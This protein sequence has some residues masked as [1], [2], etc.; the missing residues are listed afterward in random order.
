MARDLETGA[1]SKPP[2]ARTDVTSDSHDSATPPTPHMLWMEVPVTRLPPPGCW[3]PLRNRPLSQAQHQS[4]LAGW[5]LSHMALG[6]RADDEVARERD[7]DISRLSTW[8]FS[9]MDDLYGRERDTKTHTLCAA[10]L[11]P[12]T[13]PKVT[14]RHLF[15]KPSGPGL[16]VLPPPGT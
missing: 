2:W 9:V 16:P 6:A 13:C 1:G 8:L 3:S 14:H 15:P 10:P 4:R 7:A 11:D 5:T 12:P